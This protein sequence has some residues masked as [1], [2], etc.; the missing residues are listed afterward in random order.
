MIADEP[1]QE[2]LD[3]TDVN[4]GQEGWAADKA[5]ELLD[6][7]GINYN[8]AGIADQLVILC[9]AL[10]ISAIV[11]AIGKYIIAGSVKRVLKHAKSQ[12]LPLIFN[13]KVLNRIVRI[14]PTVSMLAF[15]LAFDKEG[16]VYR[17]YIKFFQLVLVFSITQLVLAVLRAIFN[18]ISNIEKFKGQPMNGVY[19]L[20]AI[21]IY[22]ICV[23]VMVSILIDKSPAYLLTGLGASAAI[24]SLVFKDTFVGF[25]A[26]FQLAANKMLKVGDWIVV[27]SQNANGIVQ[28]VSLNT[29]KVQNWDNTITTMPPTV[30]MSGSFY[31][32]RG[33]Q[34]SDGRRICRSISID[35]NTITFCTPE[36]IE[37]CRQMPLLKKFFER[38]TD[39]E[40][41]TNLT[42]FRAYAE[43]FLRSNK[44]INQSM[45]LMVR[46]LQPTEFG[47]PIEL[48]CFSSIKTWVEYEAIQSEIFDHVI[49]VVPQFGLRIYQVIASQPKD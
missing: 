26:G 43:A 7:L 22:V 8:D 45:T 41:L 30:L 16:I 35:M 19:Q 24:L 13:D 32:W 25:V 44:K 47:L 20:I 48:Y 49:A 12:N 23:I 4:M 3:A 37:K 10:L 27:P 21:F 9:V 6:W 39:V 29:V 1:I 17:I 38:H 18:V 42:L 5:K 31:N 40:N 15:S 34:E 2:D 33:M 28:E 46:Q 14:L 36:L 11:W